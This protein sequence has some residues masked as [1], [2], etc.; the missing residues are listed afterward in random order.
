M[1][2][3]FPAC[4][5]VSALRRLAVAVL[6]DVRTTRNGDVRSATSRV[7]TRPAAAYSW[8]P[9]QNERPTRCDARTHPCPAYAA[10]VA[11]GTCG[12][13]AAYDYII[14]ASESTCFY[15]PSSKALV[16][17]R[18]EDDVK[19]LC[20]DTTNESVAGQNDPSC[21]FSSQSPVACATDGG[22]E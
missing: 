16:G 17:A 13:Y 11:I 18:F 10:Q 1:R 22:A 21:Q 19:D 2:R 12:A 9:V 3:T 4:C 7:F 20:N 15:D 6:Q 5:A 8:I 14:G